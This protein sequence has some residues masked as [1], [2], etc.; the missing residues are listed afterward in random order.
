MISAEMRITHVETIHLRLPE[1]EL[2]ADGTQ[3]AFIVRIDT[4]EGVSGYGEADTSPSVAQAFVDMPA[5]HSMLVGMRQT[6]L[7]RDPFDVEPIWHDLY[8]T[9]AHAGT[10]AAAV[11]TIS[12]IDI[13]LHDLVGRALGQ[14]VY[15]LLGGR[16]RDSVRVYASALMPATPDE[17]RRHVTAQVERGHRALKLGWGPLGFD[18]R[19]DVELV[20]AAREAAGPD[21]DVMIDIGRR[22]QFKHALEMSRRLRRVRP[23]LARGA[24]VGRRHRRL[25]PLC[26]L[27]PLKIAAAEHEATIWSFR[28]WM[29]R[30]GLD[31]VQPDLARCGG[32]SQG[33]RIA[34]AAFEL[35]RECVPHA[36]STGILIAASLQMVA[37]MPGGSYCEYTVAESHDALDVLASGFEFAHGFVRVPSGPGL[38]IEIDEQKLARHRVA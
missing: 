11:H 32:F 23:L 3:D 8:E 22:W 38:G 5:S 33:R 31:V 35:G 4:D 7:G 16:F 37:S 27:S 19:R 12:A 2:R 18:A 30:G 20:A 21:V 1:I 14:P 34:Q 24:A 17:V 25:P 28:D 6:L 13:A 9:T 36:F 10:R 26:E 29:V 15:R